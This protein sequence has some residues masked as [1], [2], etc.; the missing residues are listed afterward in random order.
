VGEGVFEL[1]QT[2]RFTSDY[3][4]RGE[5]EECGPTYATQTGPVTCEWFVHDLPEGIPDGR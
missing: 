5:A 3:V 2:Y 1:G 4:I